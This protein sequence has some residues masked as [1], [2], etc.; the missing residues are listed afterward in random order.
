MQLLI[1]NMFLVSTPGK[2]TCAIQRSSRVEGITALS[3]ALSGK[4]PLFS[5]ASLAEIFFFSA[6]TVTINLYILERLFAF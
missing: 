4:F 6:T 2:L 3:S 5:A 1:K